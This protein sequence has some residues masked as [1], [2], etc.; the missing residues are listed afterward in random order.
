MSDRDLNLILNLRCLV[1]VVAEIGGA[2]IDDSAL[3]AP[4]VRERIE[5]LRVDVERRLEA[6]RPPSPP[7]AWAIPGAQP[8][9]LP[10]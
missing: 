4:D 3:S 6:M 9:D 10:F 2:I 7:P 1:A 8:D 5:F